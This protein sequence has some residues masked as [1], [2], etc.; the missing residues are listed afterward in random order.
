MDSLFHGETCPLQRG[1][2]RVDQANR[3]DRRCMRGDSIRG[4]SLP[5]WPEIRGP[6][7]FQLALCFTFVLDYES[8]PQTRPDRRQLLLAKPGSR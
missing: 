1:E 5:D 2:R 8:D 7:G 3:T 6:S 4:L